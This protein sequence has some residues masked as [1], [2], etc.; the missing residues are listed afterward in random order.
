MG[1]DAPQIVAPCL[2]TD[3]GN[4]PPGGPAR[5]AKSGIDR[6]AALLLLIV[7]SPLILAI[8]LAV[9]MTSPGPALFSQVRVGQL[10]R[11]FVLR[12]FRTMRDG[13]EAHQAALAGM[14]EADGPL[15]KIRSDPR[16]TPVGRWLRRWSLDE[17]PQ[18][19]DVVRGRM[20]LVGPRPPLPH[21][22]ARF[23]ERAHRR[24]LMKP[25]LTGLW[26]V[27]GRADLPWSDAVTFDLHYVDNWSLGLDFRVLL[28]TPAAVLGGQGAY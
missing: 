15:F 1:E 12:K 19:W 13:A 21:E 16:T 25:G 2:A 14:N 11:L 23:E 10:G 9:R 6:L 22:V 20:S 24:F 5:V 3:L 27:S 26:Q 8:V 4:L 18:L 7:F 17:L 28:K